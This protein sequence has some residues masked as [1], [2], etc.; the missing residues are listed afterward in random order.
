MKE[1]IKMTNFVEYADAMAHHLDVNKMT[2]EV[3]LHGQLK[4]PGLTKENFVELLNNVL[5]LDK[6]SKKLIELGFDSTRGVV[7]N[8]ELSTDA[9]CV[10]LCHLYGIDIEFFVEWFFSDKKKV[11]K[12]SGKT[13]YILIDTPERF[14]DF[15]MANKPTLMEYEIVK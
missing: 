7:E 10:I 14:Y 6:N 11:S 9:I 4:A 3:T 13:R 5:E 12:R 15:A 8:I 2:T 1:E